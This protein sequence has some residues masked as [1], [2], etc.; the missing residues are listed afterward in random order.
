[1]PKA[2]RCA[3]AALCSAAPSRTSVILPAPPASLPHL[4]HPSC[5]PGTPPAPVPPASIL[6]P[7]H[8]S[9]ALSQHRDALPIPKGLQP[10]PAGAFGK[11]VTMLPG[12]AE[13]GPFGGTL[14]REVGNPWCCRPRRHLCLGGPGGCAGRDVRGDN[15]R[16]QPPPR[17]SF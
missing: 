6:C 13:P 2:S 1:M 9:R 3:A 17:C 7:Q 10:A 8:P 11:R 5:I 12:A 16:R 15:G 14:G 4:R